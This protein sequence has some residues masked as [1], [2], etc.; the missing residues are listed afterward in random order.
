MEDRRAILLRSTLKATEN[1]TASS[2]EALQDLKSKIDMEIKST[3]RGLSASPEER[4]K[5]DSL[6]Q[7]LEAICPYEEPARMPNMAGNW[8]VEYTTAPPPSNGKLGPFAGIARQI[9]DLDNGTYVNYLSV[10]G[11][12]EKEFLSA[13]LEATFEEWDG[14][15]LKD[16][17][18]DDSKGDDNDGDVSN[19]VS[20]EPPASKNWLQSSISSI[21]QTQ[22]NKNP[23]TDYGADSWKVDF[24]TLTIKLFGFTLIRKA[25]DEGTSRVW[26]MS[27]LDDNGTR[28]VRA[29][30]TGEDKDA[31]LF[32]MKKE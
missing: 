11:D 18:D 19:S 3:K 32:Y 21:F 22:N 25:F 26:K 14:T 2:P 5:I 20:N 6:V 27:Y 13:K 17:R 12:I 8:I 15:I 30:R 1:P 10:P 24:K 4:A 9:I 16:E 29:G 23:G 31:M 28:I 7:S